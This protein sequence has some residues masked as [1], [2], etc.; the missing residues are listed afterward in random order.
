VAGSENPYLRFHVRDLLQLGVSLRRAGSVSLA[1][2]RQSSYVLPALQTASVS[3]SRNIG[4]YG[5]VNLTATRTSQ[6]GEVAR[7]VFLTY[8]LSLDQRRAV[9]LSANGGSG[10]GSPDD[11][12][13]ATYVQNPPLG[14]GAG[15]RVGASSA[16]NYDA[17][18]RDQLGG[19]DLD[20]QAARNHGVAGTS[21]FWSGAATLLGGELRAARQVNSSFA[22]VDVA[23]LANVPVYVDNQLVAH[24][25]A[26][27]RALIRD[28]QAYEPN[29]I[30]IDPTELPLDTTISARTMVLVPAY[31]SGVI[32]RFPVERVAGG[33]FRLVTSDGQPVPAGAQVRFNGAYFPV[34]FDGMTYVTGFDHGMA[35]E[36]RWGD[37]HC[38]FR[39]EPPPPGDPLPD[40]GTIVCRVPSIAGR[41]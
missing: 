4:E 18:W 14:P 34:T 6:A 15:Y 24:T 11:E 35:G 16:G 40:M 30:G 22:L 32:A 39:L 37:S 3:Y 36:A 31:R 2:V 9:V 23:G 1:Y 10:P 21:L 26:S 19:G 28:L 33:T 5:A 7:S 20:L 29:R 41:P 38:V 12:L 27:G 13:Y 17:Q 8:T 25:D